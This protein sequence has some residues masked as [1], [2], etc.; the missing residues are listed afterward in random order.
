MTIHL[1][2]GGLLDSLA[3]LSKVLVRRQSEVASRQQPN[4]QH[5]R[6]WLKICQVPRHGMDPG[7]CAVCNN[8][9][10]RVILHAEGSWLI[11]EQITYIYIC[12]LCKLKPELYCLPPWCSLQVWTGRRSVSNMY[13]RTQGVPKG[14]KGGG[15]G[16]GWATLKDA[17]VRS[18]LPIMMTASWG[19][20]E[21]SPSPF[22]SRHIKCCAASPAYSAKVS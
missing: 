19:P 7:N 22:L 21:G 20:S 6:L 13:C 8:I 10:V 15:G 1:C 2:S 3:W 12:L 17:Y 5:L 14:G 16:G 18:L 9:Y 4:Q 11:E